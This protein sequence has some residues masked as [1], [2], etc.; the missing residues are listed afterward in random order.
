MSEVV[1]VRRIREE[2]NGDD[3]DIFEDGSFRER[4]RLQ[5]AGTWMLDHASRGKIENILVNCVGIGK[6][7]LLGGEFPVERVGEFSGEFEM[8]GLVF[9]NRYVCSPTSQELGL[10]K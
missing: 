4:T 8:L 5:G 1:S 7:R 6:H 2:A 9:T 10:I 3:F